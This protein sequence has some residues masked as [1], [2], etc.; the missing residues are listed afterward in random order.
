VNP[1][2]DP[3]DALEIGVDRLKRR[4][5]PGADPARQGDRGLVAEVVSIHGSSL[6]VHRRLTHVLPER[7]PPTSPGPTGYPSTAMRGAVF[8]RA[9]ST[10]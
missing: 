10:G 4:H 6:G 9:I 5:L 7:N 1:W 3:L 2:I 8:M